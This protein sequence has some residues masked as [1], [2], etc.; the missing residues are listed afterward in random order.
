MFLKYSILTIISI[1]IHFC[2]IAQ[3]DPSIKPLSK[4][5]I[6]LL[7]FI[8]QDSSNDLSL[9]LFKENLRF[10]APNKLANGITLL[11]KNQSLFIQ[12]MGSGRL[13]KIQKKAPSQYQL[14]RLDSTFHSGVNFGCINVFYKD[15]LFQFGGIGF[16]K[17]KD[18]FSFFSD[19]T[20]E[21]ELYSSNTGVPVFQ[22]PE[23]GILY[24]I[25]PTSGKFYLSNS[26]HQQD[27]PNTLTTSTSDSCRVFDFKERKWMNLG[28]F[29]PVL[30]EI[31]LKSVDLKT[32]Y[33]P[34]LVFHS[35][36]ELYWLNFSK[37]Q[38]GS[39]VLDKQAEFREKWLKIYKGRPDHMYQFVIGSNFYLIRIEKD[40]QLK[41]ET[42]AL[43]EKDF[44]NVKTQPV[45]ISS[46]FSSLLKKIEPAKSYIGNAFSVLLVLLL[47]SFYNKIFKKK[48]IPKE[49]QSILYKNFFSS[50]TIV[51]KE[52][53]QAIYQLQI[54]NEQI[55][56]K[57]INKIIGVHQKDTIT[58]NKSRSDYFLK[59]N[60][61]FKLATRASEL[62]IIK[63]REE[64]DKRQ[65]N[66]NINLLFIKQIEKLFL[67][68]Q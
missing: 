65:F 55:S 34:Y 16:W 4:A 32:K 8:T 11:K 20:H 6:A 3:V 28:K 52:L 53:I 5:E 1:L 41:Y 43:K 58:Q 24:F 44:A 33:G 38:F 50:L 54:K 18:Y 56:I 15:S 9:D 68:N 37:N 21:W 63:Q 39:L 51:E 36:L 29:N 19:K 61:K 64:S 59:I 57:M 30:K 25:D 14:I 26:I 42:I 67:D 49:V 17:I 60:Q 47:Y 40:G 22:A 23:K 10:G 2:G 7:D 27:F 48:K 66:Y 12:L 46:P 45:Y 35:D 31:A 62:L 13:Y